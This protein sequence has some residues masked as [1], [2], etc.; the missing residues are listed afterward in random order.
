[1]TALAASAALLPLTAGCGASQQQSPISN[2]KISENNHGMNGIVLPRAYHM[3]NSTL[4]DTEGK[5]YQLRSDTTK[6]LTLV[7]FGYTNCPDVCRII[8]ADLA[9]SVNR[10]SAADRKK[11]GMLFVTSD[12]AR[13]TPQVIRAYLDRFNPSFEGVTGKLSTI[14]AAGK[15]LGVPISKGKRLPGGGYDVDHGTQVVGVLPNG[16]APIVWAQ[17]TP[18]GSI[19]ADITRILRTG[20]PSSKSTGSGS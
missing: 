3:P 12:P 10:L 16:S 11:V 13:D 8:M 15:S 19:A 17:G 6:P 18:P 7:F 2:V 9:A 4:T 1:V 20:M 5:P 14:L